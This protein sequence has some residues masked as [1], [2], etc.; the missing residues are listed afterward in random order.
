MHKWH[1]LKNQVYNGIASTFSLRKT[2]LPNSSLY[3]I[4]LTS[5]KCMTIYSFNQCGRHSDLEIHLL[6]FCIWCFTP[7]SLSLSHIVLVRAHWANAINSADFNITMVMIEHDVEG[8]CCLIVWVVCL[9]DV[10]F[11]VVRMDWCLPTFMGR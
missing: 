7:S 3:H 1:S 8:A 11:N 4:A 5:T 10:C 6:K 9:S 2:L